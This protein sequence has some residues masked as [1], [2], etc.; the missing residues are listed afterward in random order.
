MKDGEQDRDRCGRRPEKAVELNN[1]GSDAAARD[2]ADNYSFS[3]AILA[4]ILG[5]AIILG[6]AVA[7]YLVRDVSRGIASIVKPMQALGN[8]DLSAQ[9]PHQGEKTEI[10][11]MADTLQVFKQALIDKKAADEAAAVDAEAKIE[12]GRRVDHITRDFESMIGEIVATVSPASLCQH[13]RRAAR[14]QRN[15]I[16]LLARAFCRTV[17]VQR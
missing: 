12:R 3:F 11:A 13:H 5:T 10:G 9:V 1:T 15:R 14:R 6:I 8:G 4:S 16:G 7:F 17:A 2:A